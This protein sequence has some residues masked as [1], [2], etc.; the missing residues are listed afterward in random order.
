MEETRPLVTLTGQVVERYEDSW[1]AKV[2]IG[3][4]FGR[5]ELS[6]DA[7]ILSAR[8]PHG[9]FWGPIVLPLSQ[10]SLVER[11]GIGK[12]TFR[13]RTQSKELDRFSFTPS[14]DG[15]ELLHAALSERLGDAALVAGQR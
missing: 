5:L 14:G 13:F 10:I 4:P 1:K 7:V 6:R 12:R 15:V 3:W 8:K 2:G 9:W 11:S